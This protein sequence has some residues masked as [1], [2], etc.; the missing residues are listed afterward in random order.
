[1]SSGIISNSG[2]T[3]SKARSQK[4]GSRMAKQRSDDDRNEAR[5]FILPWPGNLH[6]HNQV[7]WRTKQKAVKRNRGIGKLVALDQ[8]ACGAKKIK[9]EHRI[10]YRFF[11]PDNRRRDAANLIQQCKPY[12]DG[13]VNSAFIE[14]DHWQISKIWF[15][16]VEISQTSPGVEILISKNPSKIEPETI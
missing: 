8:I 16:T 15:V 6:S 7:H 10:G 5:V 13:I 9:G 2:D 11:A 12:I 1:M 14:G 3:S 4:E